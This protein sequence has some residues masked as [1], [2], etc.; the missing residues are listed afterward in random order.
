MPRFEGKNVLITGAGSGFGRATALGFAREGAEHLVLLD[1]DEERL[2]AVESEVGGFGARAMSLV[3]D[4]GDLRACDEAVAEALR[5]V[6]RLNVLISNAAPPRQP[7]AFLEMRDETWLEDINTMLNASF[8]FGQRAARSMVQSGGGV[9]LFTASISA[10]GAGRGFAA[11]ASAKAGMVLLMKTM[12]IELGPYGVRVNC[13]SPGP[14]D[15]QRSVDFL[16][17][18]V[19]RGLRRSFPQAPLGR[20]ASPDDIAKAFLY[21]ASDDAAYVSG[22]NLVVDG[23]LSAQLYDAPTVRERFEGGTSS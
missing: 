12:A 8:V 16:G 5:R 6:S 14:A 23:A 15:T 7:E 19:M 3:C 10:L 21:L 13:V 11:Y 1:R 2:A 17:E 9:I 22:E 20:L 18:D 4:V